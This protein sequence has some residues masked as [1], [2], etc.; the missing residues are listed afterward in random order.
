MK[1]GKILGRI[2]K[3]LCFNFRSKEHFFVGSKRLIL[4]VNLFHRNYSHLSSLFNDIFAL[5]LLHIAS[6]NWRCDIR[7]ARNSWCSRWSFLSPNIFNYSWRRKR[8]FYGRYLFRLSVG[9]NSVLPYIQ[10]PWFRISLLELFSN[11][12][13]SSLSCFTK[14]LLPSI[15]LASLRFQ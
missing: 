2:L 8:S 3:A 1:F 14:S 7:H 9:C 15:W 10:Y 4:V 5:E 13:F 12:N 6:A 11:S